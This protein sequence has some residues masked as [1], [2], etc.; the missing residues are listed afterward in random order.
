MMHYRVQQT[1]S[2]IRADY[3]VMENGEVLYSATIPFNVKG[4]KALF[5]RSG[6]LA[7]TIER[8]VIASLRRLSSGGEKVIDYYSIKDCMGNT[9]GAIYRKRTKGFFGYYFFELHLDG[10]EYKIYEIGL[11]KQG[12]KLPVY[13]GEQ[14]IALI[15]KGTH[16][17]NNLDSY[18]LSAVDAKT[19]QISS[20]F[21]VYYDFMRFGNHG[22]VSVNSKQV[23]YVYTGNKKLKEKYNPNWHC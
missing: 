22:E 2:A 13:I 16:T 15:E 1:K 4:Y 11:G 14:Q 20:L 17:A 12:I 23:T 6:Q 10:K 8:D 5:S 3:D 7:Y 18:D 19:A 21:C 9:A